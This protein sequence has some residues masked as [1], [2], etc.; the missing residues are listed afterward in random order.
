[1]IHERTFQ[2]GTMT[3]GVCRNL[4]WDCDGTSRC[5]DCGQL[6][7]ITENSE[8]KEVCLTPGCE[9]NGSAPTT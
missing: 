8:G 7:S 6:L 2:K 3:C 5:I 9:S 1:M 4:M